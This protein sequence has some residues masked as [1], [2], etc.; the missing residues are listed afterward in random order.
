M[1]RE[2][3]VPFMTRITKFRGDKQAQALNSKQEVLAIPEAF[4]A[5]IAEGDS[6]IC[7]LKEY[8]SAS[9]DPN[10]GDALVD[11]NGAVVYGGPTF[12]RIDVVDFGTTVEIT[13]KF[14]ADEILD[15]E[16][17]DI[18]KETITAAREARKRPITT[19]RKP[20]VATAD[21]EPVMS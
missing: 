8:N 3:N 6:V 1:K 12:T 2:L 17:T 9:I 7:M 18:V 5:D 4:R 21:A 13:Q 11:A 14:Y 19:D 16:A 15:A 20:V 10:T